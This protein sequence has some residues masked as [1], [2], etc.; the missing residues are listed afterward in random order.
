[1]I[2]KS[3]WGTGCVTTKIPGDFLLSYFYGRI[4]SCQNY[5]KKQWKIL[6]VNTAGQKWWGM[7]TLIIALNV[8][9]VNMWI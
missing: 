5:F 3:N 4:Y 7:G 6:L 8:C 2:K 1:M 9:G